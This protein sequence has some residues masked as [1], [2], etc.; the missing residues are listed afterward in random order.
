MITKVKA[1]TGC[2][3][4]MA[5]RWSTNA[6]NS[7]QNVH[8]FSPFQLVFRKNPRLPNILTDRPPALDDDI[9]IKIIRDNMNALDAARQAFIAS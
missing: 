2:S 9:Q 6:K 5:I 1:D 3:L 4:D 7:L 8:E